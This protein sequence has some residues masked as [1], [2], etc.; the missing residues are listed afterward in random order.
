MGIVQIILNNTEA[1]NIIFTYY[2]HVLSR[3]DGESM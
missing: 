2:L 3:L 1:S